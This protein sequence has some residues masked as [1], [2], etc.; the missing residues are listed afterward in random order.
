MNSRMFGVSPLAGQPWESRF[1]HR[2]DQHHFSPILV[3][4]AEEEPVSVPTTRAPLI[5]F[6]FEV[7]FGGK[8]GSSSV[9]GEM[10]GKP[11]LSCVW[12]FC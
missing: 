3:S 10:L 8:G 7:L 6:G 11:L 9:Y 5:S 12:G 2:P 1:A 4:E